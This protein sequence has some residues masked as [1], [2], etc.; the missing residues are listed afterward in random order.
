MCKLRLQVLE[1]EPRIPEPLHAALRAA[2]YRITAAQ[3]EACSQDQHGGGSGWNLLPDLRPS[4]PEP[5]NLQRET[6][7]QSSVSCGASVA[8]EPTPIIGNGGRSSQPECLPTPSIST[9]KQ[10]TPLCHFRTV[11]GYKFWP[12]VA[13]GEGAETEACRICRAFLVEAPDKKNRRCVVEISTSVRGAARNTTR[14]DFEPDEPVWD[15]V[16]RNGLSSYLWERDEL[17]PENLSL[18]ALTPQQLQIVC[19]FAG[20][21]PR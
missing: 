12:I 8:S 7:D 4:G 21:L 10:P 14:R 16:A 5:V 9:T 18:Y 11:N 2:G 20:M 6:Q 1:G 3:E 19:S 13:P 17:P 15:A